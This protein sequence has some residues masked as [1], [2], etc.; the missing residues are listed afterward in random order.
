M[1]NLVRSWALSAKEWKFRV[2]CVYV[3]PDFANTH[4]EA[5]AW[6]KWV[7]DSIASL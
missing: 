3:D 2:R 7:Q 5:V 1:R 6:G 4:A